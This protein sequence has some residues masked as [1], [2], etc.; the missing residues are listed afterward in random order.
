MLQFFLPSN[1]GNTKYDFCN[2]YI[3]LFTTRLS[4]LILNCQWFHFCQNLVFSILAFMRHYRRHSIVA[5]FIIAR[6]LRQRFTFTMAVFAIP[7]VVLYEISI[8]ISSVVNKNASGQ[9]RM[10]IFKKEL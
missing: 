3:V 2:E 4:G 5:I 6:L 8:G 10:N 7:M 1:A 9:N